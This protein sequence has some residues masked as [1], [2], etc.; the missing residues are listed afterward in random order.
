[1]I[2]RELAGTRRSVLC[3]LWPDVGILSNW[4]GNQMEDLRQRSN[5]IQF[6]L[7]GLLWPLCGKWAGSG[8][9]RMEAGR[10]VRGYSGG[11]GEGRW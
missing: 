2:E 4:D 7:K 11:P 5:M 10:P 1:M 8:G 9:W 6:S 3:R